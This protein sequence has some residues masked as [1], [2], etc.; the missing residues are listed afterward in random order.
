MTRAWSWA[1]A[2]LSWPRS[3]LRCHLIHQLV[4]HEAL[5][6]GLDRDLD[7]RFIVLALVASAMSHES[8][9]DLDIRFIE[10]A[11]VESERRG[12]IHQLVL[13]R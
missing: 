10:L 12:L 8:G 6:P 13:H 1:S 4:L 7:F 3:R 2:S 9:L 11:Q 5:R